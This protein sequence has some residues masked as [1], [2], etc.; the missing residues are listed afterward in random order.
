M[1]PLK[2]ERKLRPVALP[3]GSYCALTGAPI[4][5]GVPSEALLTSASSAPHEIFRVASSDYVSIEAARCYKH[6]KGGLTGNLLLV[7]Q[8]DGTATGYRPMISR[9]SAG[10]DRPCW[11]RV[12]YGTDPHVALQPGMQV[13]A[14][15][16]DSFKH[17]DWIRAEI[18]EVG[19]AW[20]PYLHA[21]SDDRPLTV[22]IR[23]LRAVLALCEYVYGLGYDKTSLTTTLYHHYGM[24]QELGFAAVRRLD[25]ALAPWRGTDELLLA[26][27]VVQRPGTLDPIT[28][29]GLDAPEDDQWLIPAPISSRKTTSSA[30]P[31]PRPTPT[32]PR[33]QLPLFS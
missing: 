1:P 2:G 14:I 4:R 26:A 24:L 3:P 10:D 7:V 8:P 16:S 23:R 22:D 30:S 11:Q 12:I 25:A 9:E 6:F 17:R 19:P 31:P 5:E 13:L 18:S 20:R 21:G 27:L 28:R 29:Q 15:F 32:S 33:S